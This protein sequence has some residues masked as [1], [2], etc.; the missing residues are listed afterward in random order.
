MNTQA[1]IKSIIRGTTVVTLAL[2]IATAGC[3][4]EDEGFEDIEESEKSNGICAEETSQWVLMGAAVA[5]SAFATFALVLIPGAEI[6]DAAFDE[7]DLAGGCGE[8]DLSAASLLAIKDIVT[9]SLE[10]NTVREKVAYIEAAREFMND[11]DRVA[12][13]NTTD[14]AGCNEEGGWTAAVATLQQIDINLNS[15]YNYF[16]S[17]SSESDPHFGTKEMMVAA[18][19]SMAIKT[20]IMLLQWL[21]KQQ[22]DFPGYQASARKYHDE[23]SSRFDKYTTAKRDNFFL[24]KK[25]DTEFTMDGLIDVCRWEYTVPS[26]MVVGTA[27]DTNCDDFKAEYETKLSEDLKRF[28]LAIV[29]SEEGFAAT[30][31]DLKSMAEEATPNLCQGEVTVI[32]TD[33]LSGIFEAQEKCTELC[34][35]AGAQFWG[36]W[37]NLDEGGSTCECHAC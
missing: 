4:V 24:T 6:F 16:N 7:V 23:L 3:D 19:L 12:C 11:Y 17:L 30:L 33:R 13:A 15:D 5:R 25:E 21:L 27:M 29:G 37:D 14:P 2:G 1:R 26:G 18:S 20:E 28:T 32:K 36:Q 8:G 10:E 34:N 22:L 31:G 9:T 35:G